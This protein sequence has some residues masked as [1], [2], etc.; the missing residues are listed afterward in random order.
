MNMLDK[1][2]DNLN[3]MS[4]NSSM[5]FVTYTSKKTLAIMPATAEID[6]VLQNCF[7]YIFHFAV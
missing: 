2:T 5:S 3:A 4:Y 7:G 6:S 1:G